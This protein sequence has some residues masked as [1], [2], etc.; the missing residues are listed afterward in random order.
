MLELLQKLISFDTTQ[1]ENEAMKFIQ[2]FI[3]E[4]YGDT[5]MCQQQ[6][7]EDKGRYNLIIKNTEDP[8]IILAWHV[9]T[10]PELSK[11]QF[12][13]RIEDNRLYGRGAV[14]MKAWV[15]INI[16]L[17]DFM[18]KN[19]IKFWVLCYADEE[20]NFLWMKKFTEIYGGKIH[21]KLTIVTEP[22]NTAIYTWFRGIAAINLEIKGKSVHSAR[23][24]FGINAIEEYVHFIDHLEKHIQ[25]KD[26]HEYISLTNLA[27]LHGGIYKNEEIIRQDNIVPSVAKGI[28]SLRLGNDFTYQELE[29]F[30]QEYF[31]QKW[32]EIIHVQMNVWYNPL[33]Q[34]GLQEKY[35]KYGNVEEWYTFGYSDI[36]LIK[37]HIGGDCL[38]IGPW[39]NEQSHQADEYVEIESIEKAKTIIEN[40]LKDFSISNV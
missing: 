22:T 12:I 26:T 2:K 5:V 16:E 36:Q 11:E 24:H 1:R 39:P 33:I 17:I 37:E 25:S 19:D 28:F 14:D 6:D 21:P 9:D 40:I 35:G 23:K 18:L 32:I 38:L 4:K 8:E 29:K 34:I 7:I 13:P 3:Q 30:M 27:G 10:V 31:T 20:N 15:A